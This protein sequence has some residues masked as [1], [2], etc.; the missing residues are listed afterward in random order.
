MGKFL[1]L[2]DVQNFPKIIGQIQQVGY[3]WNNAL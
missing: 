1:L 2:F 3:G